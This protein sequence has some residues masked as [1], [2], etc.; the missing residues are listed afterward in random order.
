MANPEEDI[1]ALNIATDATTLLYSFATPSGVSYGPL[2]TDGNFIAWYLQ[3]D[4]S[5]TI[6]AL[7]LATHQTTI[8]ASA[9][10]A[11]PLI[12]LDGI[13]HG[14]VLWERPDNPTSSATLYLTNL[15]TMQQK[16][17]AT[18]VYAS[19][20]NQIVWPNIFYQ[21]ATTEAAHIYNMQTGHDQVETTP[22]SDQ[23]LLTDGMIYAFAAMEKNGVPY[24][25][26]LGMSTNGVSNGYWS[27]IHTINTK[28]IFGFEAN[29]RFIGWADPVSHNPH[30]WDLIMHREIVIIPDSVTIPGFVGNLW[31]KWLVYTTPGRNATAT[32]IS[33]VDTSLLPTK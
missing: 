5:Q 29:N 7:N 25:Q 15:T 13:A 9:T 2:V 3:T 19:S 12:A 16:T 18:T 4:T 33:I 10:Q 17:I 32:T 21:S 23:F 24:T 6:M 28:T 26:I 31:G 20:S 27:A 11:T 14:E 8:V 30:L 1:A 22:V